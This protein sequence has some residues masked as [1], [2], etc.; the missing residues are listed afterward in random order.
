MSLRLNVLVLLGAFSL[1]GCITYGYLP[2]IG[3]RVDQIS[4]YDQILLNQDDMLIFYRI[5][6]YAGTQEVASDLPK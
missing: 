5:S 3:S 6:T 4:R 1:S 2:Q